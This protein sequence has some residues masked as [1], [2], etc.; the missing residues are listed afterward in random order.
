MQYSLTLIS[1]HLYPLLFQYFL[2]SVILSLAF[3]ITPSAMIYKFILTVR[4]IHEQD[5]FFDF[6][7]LANE[8]NCLAYKVCELVLAAEWMWLSVHLLYVFS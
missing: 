4:G 6:V 2:P 7:Y 5:L 3:M 1:V 8:C